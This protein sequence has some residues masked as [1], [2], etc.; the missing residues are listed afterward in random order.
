MFV[1]VIILWRIIKPESENSNREFII[2][3][4]IFYFRMQIL[5]VDFFFFINTKFEFYHNFNCVQKKSTYLSDEN[6]I[7]EHYVIPK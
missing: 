7:N 6:C 3:R 5:L 2:P 1:F 4:Q